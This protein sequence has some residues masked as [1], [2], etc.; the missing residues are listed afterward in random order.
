MSGVEDAHIAIIGLAGRFPGAR[1]VNEFWHN[2]LGGVESITF[3]S[4]DE[5]REAG[6][7]EE[8]IADASYVKAAPITEG[9]DMFDAAYFGMSP[10]E[11]EIL[12]PQQRIFLE[13]CETALQHSG[14]DPASFGGRIG[15]Y[16]GL[17]FNNYLEDNVNKN[18]DVVD[19]MGRLSTNISNTADYLATGVSYRL[20]LRGPS[21]TCL[22]A[23]STSMVA[24]HLA[25]QALR[26][27]EC[28][29][30][31]AGGVEEFIPRVS[32]YYYS[33][34]GL[35]SPDGHCR[36]F[37]AKARGTVFGSGAGVVLLKRLD[38]ALADGD[39]VLAVI[40]ATAINNDG[41]DKGAFTAPSISG[42]FAAVSDALSRSGVD[43][44]TISYVEAHGTSTFVGDP[45]EVNALTKAFRAHTDRK[46]YCGIGSVKTNVG[47]LG[48][49]AGVTGLI[50]TVLA[51]QHRV[52]PPSINFDEPNPQIDFE[53]SPFYVNTDL[54]PWK[55]DSGPLRA[56]VSSFG[57][58][59]TNGHLILEEAPAVEPSSRPLRSHQLLLLSARTPTA[60]EANANAVGAHLRDRPEEL[61]DAAYTL[62]VGRTARPVRSF[63]VTTDGTEAGDRL[64]AGVPQPSPGV[65]PPRGVKREIAFVFPGQ[66]A[67]YPQM[68]RDLYET[69]P[70]FRTE[71]DEC[72]EVLREQTGW[73]LRELLFPSDDDAAA[74][75]DR[76][77][78]TAVTQPALFVVEYA[79]AKL[80]LSWG[81]RPESMVGHSVGEYVAATLAGVFTRDDAL[82]LVAARGA[83]MQELP[84]GSMLA[85]PLSEQ[86]VS[87]MLPAD[88]SLAAVNAPDLAVVSGPD[89]AIEQFKAVLA[90]QGMEGRPLHT[91]HAFHSQMMDP[92]LERF[93]A[94]VAAVPR[95]EP[96]IPFVSNLSGD[97]ITAAQATDP[98]YWA[99]H[100][101]GAVRF[102]DA[103]ALL[104]TGASRVLV[105][106]GPGQTLSSLARRQLGTDRQGLAVSTMRHPQ[107]RQPDT[108]VLLA[109]L[110]QVWQTGADID[111]TALW[112]DERRH[113]VALPRVPYEK[114]RS[115][116]DGG[117]QAA[118]STQDVAANTETGPYYVPVWKETSAPAPVDVDTAA[119][120]VVFEPAD[121]GVAAELTG[122]LRTAGAKVITVRAGAE[123]RADGDA[124]TVRAGEL[125]DYSAVVAAA[126]A[127]QPERLKMVHGWLVGDLA[128]DTGRDRARDG[129]DRGFFSILSAAQAVSRNPAS[130]PLDLYLLTS[131]LRDVVGGERIE[132][133]K[134][135]VDGFVKLLPKEF[136]DTTCRSIDVSTGRADTVADQVLREISSGS[137]DQVVA[138]RGRKRW[139][140]SHEEVALDGVGAAQR[141]LRDGGVYLITG[142]LGGIGLV[143]ARDLAEQHRAKLV[144]VGR[145][146]LP[147]REEWRDLLAGPD[148]Q[149]TAR[150]KAVEEIESLGG[151][152]LVIAADVTDTESLRAVRAQAEAAFGPV[153]GVLHAAGITGGGMLETRQ[154]ADAEAVLA[155]KVFGT[156]AIEEVFGDSIDLLVLYSSF[157]VF[158]GDFGLFDY[159]SANSILDSYAQS[160]AGGNTHVVS[161]N[162]PI[163]TK[164]GMAFDID[165]PD[166]LTSFEMGDRYEKVAHPLLGSRLVRAG[167]DQVIFVKNLSTEDWVT[168]EHQLDSLPTMP[169]TSLVELVRAAYEEVT[170]SRTAEIR[171][172]V[173][174]RPVQ[175]VDSRTVHIILTPK[176]NG[177][178][179]VMIADADTEGGNP[180][181]FTTAKVGPGPRD[182]APRHDVSAWKATCH[183]ED[184]PEGV[185]E[186]IIT[187]GPRWQQSIRAHWHGDQTDQGLFDELVLLELGE[188]FLGDLD[189][190]GLHP[191]LLDKATAL[192]QTVVA[193]QTSHLPFGYD[194]ITVRAP[195]P[196]RFYSYIRHLDDTRGALIRTDITLADED[197][198]EL[199]AIKGF[200]M[201]EY[202]DTSMS[203]SE[204]GDTA[205][206]ATASDEDDE[207]KFSIARQL[208]RALL[209]SNEKAFGIEP[210]DG[211]R[212]LRQMLDSAA[213]PQIIVCPDSFVKRMRMAGEVTRD[214]LR[215]QLMAAPK[216]AASVATRSLMTPYVEP[217]S[218]VQRVLTQMWADTLG[219][220][221][222]GIDDDFFDLNGN[223]LIAVQLVARIREQFQVDLTVAGL[224]EARTS[225]ALSEKIDELLVEMLSSLSDEEAAARLASITT[226]N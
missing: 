160:R 44:A 105:E 14:Y 174:M 123:Q 34:G 68:G 180:V 3:F 173:F 199:V 39:N 125:A 109:A 220:D 167:S 147:P 205:P 212:M 111:F 62:A 153:N 64:A 154:F 72:A 120:W 179:D 61:A 24:I 73:D 95:S 47:H 96:T 135:G 55:A 82:R 190:F 48:A 225:R 57:V 92:I 43:P 133:V 116:L 142:G 117:P 4:D 18:P 114:Q 137:T 36:T 45:I 35:Y 198:V 170:G 209:R 151:E 115:W 152:V 119:A 208:E 106:L 54:T 169:G 100:L 32:G 41:N 183:V 126:L 139:L 194:R 213:A 124:Y 102:A 40:R 27:G 165:V 22:S 66:G 166:L 85:V 216:A 128:G 222:V 224:F 60:L 42:Q 97:W 10:R 98:A 221:K 46:Q 69:E 214:A 211:Y 75:A 141:L 215:E 223:S 70:V 130:P 80:V 74:A 59:G 129:L 204:G 196:R 16:G 65:I 158:S 15:V 110:G 134:S 37:D 176:P 51:M 2:L 127:D 77:N 56:S 112:G 33:E 145:S 67:Q 172:V 23:C 78:Q 88:L 184:E 118:A 178:Y 193:S 31:L 53:N 50:K 71:I 149:V 186:G 63:L 162:W 200:T 6:V 89:Q 161:I 28:E 132:P 20:G 143:T 159:C 177:V 21:F 87:S 86:T 76:L 210:E 157:T 29:M 79:M 155:A 91:S 90:V 148:T 197:G 38:A 94:L 188:E 219:L 136:S 138:Y 103:V 13:E 202:N 113:R 146:G 84:A 52:L 207:S 25:S 108:A 218:D 104:T 107:Q 156:L 226:R 187:L 150:I 121:G 1:D 12:D 195:L 191:A 93:T 5:L 122:R 49:A 8:T 26:S 171:D 217:E 201:F 99:A 17:G 175:F 131:E 185:T 19:V 144:L 182:D 140:W 203:T 7:S 101:R 192:G 83:L 189:E 9:A 168:A 11:A 206:A 30:A 181:E 164:L 81:L 163:W 58:G